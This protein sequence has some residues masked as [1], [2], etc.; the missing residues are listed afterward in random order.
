[1]T[2]ASE[3]S[4]EMNPLSCTVRL[5]FTPQRIAHTYPVPTLA[6]SNLLPILNTRTMEQHEANV[7]TAN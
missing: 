3:I 2:K 7:A 1:M 4:G 6:F 5:P